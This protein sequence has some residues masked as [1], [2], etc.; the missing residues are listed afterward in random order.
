MKKCKKIKQRYE[1]IKEIKQ[2]QHDIIEMLMR[3]YMERVARNKIK[4]TTSD[5]IKLSKYELELVK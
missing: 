1:T 4:L 2:R 5:F 3:L